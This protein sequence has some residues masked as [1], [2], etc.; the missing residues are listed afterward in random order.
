MKAMGKISLG[1]TLAA[2]M[3]LALGLGGCGGFG[4]F[5]SFG[6]SNQTATLAPEESQSGPEIPASIRASEVI[7]R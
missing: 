7:G 4:G 5:P 6:S 3:F 1:A 2:P